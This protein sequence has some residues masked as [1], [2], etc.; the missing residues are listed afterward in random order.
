MTPEVVLRALLEIWAELPALVG[1]DWP[2]IVPDLQVLVDRLKT[3]RDPDVTTESC[4]PF[5]PIRRRGRGAGSGRGD[6]GFDEQ[7]APSRAPPS[8]PRAEHQPW[9]TVRGHSAMR[10]GLGDADGGPAVAGVASLAEVTGQL[11]AWSPSRARRWRRSRRCP[12]PRRQPMSCPRL[13]GRDDDCRRGHDG[14]GHRLARDDRWSTQCSSRRG[15]AAVDPGKR[16]IIQL[17]LKTN[18]EAVDESR[19]EID[20]P[21]TGEATQ[22][23]SMSGRRTPAKRGPGRGP[24]GPDPARHPQ[25]DGRRDG[26]ASARP[27]AKRTSAEGRLP[28]SA[29]SRSRSTSSASASGSEAAATRTSTNSRRLHS[30]SLI[31]TSRGRSPATC[32]VT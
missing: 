6:I 28:T 24:T 17:L 23:Y 21:A 13:D 4:W 31:R 29:R 27:T 9:A 5:V 2:K 11:G 14:R 10:G 25:T 26:P 19:A 16:L 18:L 32:R 1:P 3:S 8:T 30:A 15:A 12:K 22:V 20:V 7:P